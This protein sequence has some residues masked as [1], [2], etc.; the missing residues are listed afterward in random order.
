VDGAREALGEERF[1]AAWE[2]GRALSLEDAV[3]FAL[4]ES[5]GG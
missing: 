2:V 4:E 1:A 5:H 3:A